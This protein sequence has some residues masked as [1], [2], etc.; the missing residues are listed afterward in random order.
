MIRAFRGFT[1]VIVVS[2]GFDLSPM[3]GML[4]ERRGYPAA[5][6]MTIWRVVAHNDRYSSA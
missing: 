4:M 1:Q 5:P 2:P 3:A 6:G